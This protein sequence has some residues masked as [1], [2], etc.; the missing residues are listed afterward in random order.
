VSGGTVGWVTL[1]S[2]TST[3]RVSRQHC[4]MLLKHRHYWKLEAFH[5]TNQRHLRIFCYEIEMPK[6]AA[7]T[8]AA[9]SAVRRTSVPHGGGR[10]PSLTVRSH[11]GSNRP[12]TERRHDAGRAP[13]YSIPWTGGYYWSSSTLVLVIY[14]PVLSWLVRD[15]TG[16]LLNDHN[17][18]ISVVLEC[19][20]VEWKCQQRQAR[21]LPLARRWYLHT[22]VS[23]GRRKLLIGD[24]AF[25]RSEMETR[26]AVN[27]LYGTCASRLVQ[28]VPAFWLHISYVDRSG[29]RSDLD[30]WAHSVIRKRTG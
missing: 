5:I 24:D 11:L 30:F 28:P 14:C 22:T 23:A 12:V 29:A 21:L 4:H 19:Q 18:P 25:L 13:S 9:R 20:W 10:G 15:S 26:G 2:F 27:V 16:Q 1:L 3:I 17:Q 8:R 7:H 6:K